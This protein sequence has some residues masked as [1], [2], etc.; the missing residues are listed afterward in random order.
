VV[1]SL[2]RSIKLRI[3]LSSF[4]AMCRMIGAGVGVGIVPES[5]AR[6]NQSAADIALV[7][8]VDAWSVRERYILVRNR[9]A[10]PRYAESLI[11]TLCAHY[12]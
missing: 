11:E 6:R 9:A 2:G 1:D 5:A 4:D 12:R 3:Q 7:E 8:L 10:L